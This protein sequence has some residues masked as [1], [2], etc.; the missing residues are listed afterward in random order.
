MKSNISQS[1]K[2]DK[3]GDGEWDEGVYSLSD[4]A[5]LRRGLRID[6]GFESTPKVR[7]PTP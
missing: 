3:R 4:L 1:N 5:R 7:S 2:D 6:W